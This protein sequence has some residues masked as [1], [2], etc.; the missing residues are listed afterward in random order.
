MLQVNKIKINNIK[1]NNPDRDKYFKEGPEKAL[2]F[3]FVLVKVY[4][5]C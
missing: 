4:K 3:I 5:P 2:N 1:S